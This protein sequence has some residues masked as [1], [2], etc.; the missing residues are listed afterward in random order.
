MTGTSTDVNQCYLN[1]SECSGIKK[2][3]F[4]EKCYFLAWAVLPLC[5]I[6]LPMDAL[7]H[8]YALLG[9]VPA[10]LERL[11]SMVDSR[12]GATVVLLLQLKNFLV[13]YFCSSNLLSLLYQL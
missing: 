11:S 1:D 12:V 9:G 13:S 6:G 10:H 8:N 7:C 4:S 5:N 2:Y 3:Y